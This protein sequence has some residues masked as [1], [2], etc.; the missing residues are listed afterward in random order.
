MVGNT[1][2][3]S[4]SELNLNRPKSIKEIESTNNVPTEK[5]PGPD[6]FTGAFYQ[7]F[8]EEVIPILYKLFQKKK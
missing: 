2:G 5:A 7:P 3:F 6:G 8:K 4:K 1:F